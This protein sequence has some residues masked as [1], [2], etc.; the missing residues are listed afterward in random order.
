MLAPGRVVAERGSGDPPVEQAAEPGVARLGDVGDIEQ[1]RAPVEA[2][3]LDI[4]ADQVA[5]YGELVAKAS[6]FCN[7]STPLMRF[8]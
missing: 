7:G 1:G 6:L 8:R 5:G 2:Q 3:R 4:A